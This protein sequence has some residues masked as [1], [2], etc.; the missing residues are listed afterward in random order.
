ML[1]IIRCERDGQGSCKGCNDK[2]IWNRHWTCFLYK[3]EGA[4]RL[5]L[6]EMH[7][8]NYEER[9]ERLNMEMSIFEKDGKTYTRFKITLKEFKLKFLRNLL[10]KYGI[11]TSE[12][13][14]KNSRYIY[15]EKERDW[16][17]GET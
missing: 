8:R 16:I 10:T 13:V 3:I 9:G 6:R 5:L 12:P 14:K 7:K 2:G 1:K 17:N 11:D 15:F 4:G